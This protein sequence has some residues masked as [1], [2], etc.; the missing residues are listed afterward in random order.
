MSSTLMHFV[1][2]LRRCMTRE[3]GA[4]RIAKAE[5][6]VATLQ[7]RRSALVA[8]GRELADER[9]SVAIQASAY[10]PGAR[11]RL[12]EINSELALIEVEL[13]NTDAA[14]T[15]AAKRLALAQRQEQAA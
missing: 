2:L 1:R 3:H 13:R 4:E 12:R 11:A 8:Q 14:L 7:R 10:E 15:E 5:A 6:D 9:V